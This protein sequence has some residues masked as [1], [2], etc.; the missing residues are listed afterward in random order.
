MNELIE[1]AKEKIKKSKRLVAFTGAGISVAS[2]IPPFRGP[3][4]LWS[5]YDPS[6]LDIDFFLNNTKESWKL[7]KEIFYSFLLKDIKPNPGHIALAKLGCPVI[8]QNIDNLHQAAGSK[9]VVEF[10]GTAETLVC[11]SCGEKFKRDEVDFESEIPTCKACGGILKPDFVFF[12][13]PIPKDAFDKSIEL[14]K[15]CDCMLVIGTTGEIMPASQ[16]PYI[17]KRSKALIIEVNPNPSNYTY[18][19]TDIFLQGKAEEILP[20]LID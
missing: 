14:A 9:D 18:E 7:I 10:H 2:G 12:K 20:K 17:A 8:T 16:I 6:M 11:M 5:K 13:E 3:D 1:K 19:I 4:G 15:T